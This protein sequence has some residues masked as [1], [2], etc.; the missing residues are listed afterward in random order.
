MKPKNFL[1]P[2]LITLSILLIPFIAMRFTSEVEWTAFD[3]IAMGILLFTS[4]ITYEFFASRTGSLAFKAATALAV[5]TCLLLTWMNLAVGIIGNENNPVNLLYFLVPMV[6]FIGAISARF[7][8]KA[9]SRVL[10]VAASTLALIPIIA[11]SI[12]R[13]SIATS[14]ELFGVLSVLLLNT[15]F[16]TLLAGSGLLFKNASVSSDT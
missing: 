2:A 10:Y 16:V 4:G 5:G 14:D 6:L 3:F 7:E 12:N 11:L 9:L 15:F 8:A 1:R 13:P